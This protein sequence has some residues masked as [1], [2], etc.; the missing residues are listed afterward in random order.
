MTGLQTYEP[1][2]PRCALCG[3][4]AVGACAACHRLVCAECA[5]V[6]TGAAQPVAYCSVCM[7]RGAPRAHW[8][9]L[10]SVLALVALAAAAVLGLLAL[11]RAG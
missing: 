11:L 7:E 4:E 8:R 5:E 6:V 1:G 9:A 10:G 2:P 3:D